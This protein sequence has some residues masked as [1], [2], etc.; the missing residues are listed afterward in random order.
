MWHNLILNLIFYRTNEVFDTLNL[1]TVPVN[2]NRN[3]NKCCDE[4]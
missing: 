1:E 4:Q 3:N 2:R